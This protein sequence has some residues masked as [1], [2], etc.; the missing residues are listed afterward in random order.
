MTP[1]GLHEVPRPVASWMQ[2]YLARGFRLVFWNRVGEPR[3]WKGPHHTGW[4]DKDRV[5][6]PASYHDGMNV[7]TFTGHEIQ[8]GRFLADVDFDWA[9]GLP[10]A[11]RLLPTT[12]Y[13]LGRASQPLT[14][15]FYTTPERVA[16]VKYYDLDNKTCLVEIRGGDSTHQTMLPP[17][18]HPDNERRCPVGC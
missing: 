14:H 5:Y 10:L 11:K 18:L 2:A 7:G 16:S 6:D 15:A 1:A 13:G 4:N 12:G 17:S 9:G 3:D 8:P